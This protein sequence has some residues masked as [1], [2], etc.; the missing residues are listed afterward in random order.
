M[1]I[2]DIGNF[3]FP[4]ISTNEAVNDIFVSKIFAGWSLH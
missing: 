3:F 4:A 2:F 1:E